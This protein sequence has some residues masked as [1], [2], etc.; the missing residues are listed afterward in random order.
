MWMRSDILRLVILYL[1]GG[2]YADVDLEPLRS[3]EALHGSTRHEVRPATT[4][5]GGRLK[6]RFRLQD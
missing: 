6:V 2:V 1:H 3:F 5:G 4:G